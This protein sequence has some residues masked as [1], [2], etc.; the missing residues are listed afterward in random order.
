MRAGMLAI[1]LAIAV[2]GC[3]G[4]D[5]GG[6]LGTT[7]PTPT[8]SPTP[9]PPP[10]TYS[11]TKYAALTGDQNF[12]SACA[13]VALTGNP[14]QARFATPYGNGVPLSYTAATDTYRAT[15]DGVQSTFA[16]GD[17]DPAAPAGTQ[18][19]LKVVN[20]FTE[21]FSIGQP[22]AAGTALEYVRGFGL[23]ARD[24]TG[25]ANQFG[26][27]FGVSTFVGDAP[28]GS[29]IPFA[30]VS[31]NGAAYIN[32][33][34]SMLSYSLAGSTATL[35]ANVVTGTITITLQLVGTEQK[36]S[37][38][39]GGIVILGSY[40]GSG[41]I[42]TTAGS[43][44]GSL[45]DNVSS[46]TVNGTFGGWFFGPQGAEGA[47]VLVMSGPQPGTNNLMTVTATIAAIRQ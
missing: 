26:C 13:V 2:T 39:V 45:V 9:S 11:Y 8:P 34:G 10:P 18:R 30:R 40:T 22:T 19:Y 38:P 16:P 21:R 7:P 28:A 42:D 25:Q 37:G 3:G 15:V 29:N 33:A 36:A 46:P 4:D 24:A 31:L 5:S 35:A 14:F 23:T 6:S 43:F 32:D 41:S 1:A 44:S 20:G 47:A 12:R 17:R 27:I